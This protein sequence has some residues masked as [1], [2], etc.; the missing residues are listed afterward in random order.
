ME[1]LN[2]LLM[3]IELIYLMINIIF[4]N[5]QD[6]LISI[7]LLNL[8]DYILMIKFLNLMVNIIDLLFQDDYNQN[9]IHVNYINV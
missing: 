8:N 4:L 6:V 3:T 5:N 2:L 7:N 1:I 9:K